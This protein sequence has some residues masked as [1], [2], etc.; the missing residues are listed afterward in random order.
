M[1][2]PPGDRGRPPAGVDRAAFAVA[3]SSTAA[4]HRRAGE[5]DRDVGV[6]RRA[7]RRAAGRGAPAVL[8]GPA[9][10]GQPAAGHRAVR[11]GLRGGL[12][13]RGRW[14][15]TRT[16]AGPARR[17][18]SRPA[19]RWRRC[20]ASR[21]RAGTAPGCPGTPCR[22]SS[23]G[24]DEDDDGAL[25][26]ELLPSCGRPDRRDP[27]RRARR[28]RAR[29]ARAVA[30]AGSAPLA[31]PAEPAARVGPSGH[32]LAMR[33]TM[34]ASRRTGW[35]PMELKRYDQVRRPL[36]V[37]LL[38]DVSQSMQGY[39]TAYLHLMRVFARTRHAETFAFSTSLTRLTP[40]ARAPVAGGR[41]RAGRV[42]G[43]RPVR[44]HAPGPVPARAAPRRGTATSS[45]AGCW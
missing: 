18:R 11:P 17:R 39:A 20:R 37:T 34:A 1:T 19:T 35:E 5:P 24:S 33:E 8:A 40:G 28:R 23:S 25:L 43:G 12:R 31:D 26:P 27:V 45:A 36:T 3:L 10:P 16:P 14:P 21:A 32:R 42:A 4:G 41:G 29:R 6:H 7:R 44:R 30:G 22:G 13:R 15:S 2:Q 38:C 9:H